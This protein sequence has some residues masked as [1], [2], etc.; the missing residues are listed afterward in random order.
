[1]Q[2]ASRVIKIQP[3]TDVAEYYTQ[4]P[5]SLMTDVKDKVITAQ[6][7]TLYVY[8]LSRQGNNQCLWCSIETIAG[9]MG[10]SVPQVSRM[11]KNL[12]K[13][14]HITRKRRSHGSTVT[15]CL[16]KVTQAG[17]KSQSAVG[18]PKAV[19]NLTAGILAR[20]IGILEADEDDLNRALQ[21]AANCENGWQHSRGY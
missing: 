6:E 13:A 16:T 15:E 11:L 9:D 20:P 17:K 3:K 14:G 10:Y 5:N 18:R 7:H 8:L 12:E 19:E 4:V 1:M 21:F 2:D